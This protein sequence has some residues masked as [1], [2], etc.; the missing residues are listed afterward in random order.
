MHRPAHARARARA[1][2]VALVAAVV[3]LAPSN[4]RAQSEDQRNAPEVR[5]LDLNGVHGV[6]RADLARAISTSRST[7]RSPLLTPFCRL[8]RSPTFVDRKYLDRDEFRRD[9]LRILV[10]YWKRGFREAQVD[11]SVTRIA[12]GAVRVVFDIRE[13]RPTVITSL[14]IEHDTAVLSQRRVNRLSIL[15]EGD[16]LN[17]VV[18]DTMRMGFQFA[19]WDRGYADAEVDTVITVDPGKPSADVLLR[20]R[21]NWRTTVGSI[22]VR[23]NQEV[24]ARTIQNTI[25]L[26]PG[27]VFR[28]VDLLESQ[29]NLY[30]SNL[31]R[32]ASFSIPPRP[33]SVK[34]INIEVRETKM[35]EAR[36][37]AGVNNIDYIQVDGGYTNYNLF[38]G[39]RQFDITGIIGNLGAQALEGRGF[40][41]EPATDFF[42]SS[43]F[44]VPT[45]QVSVDLTQPAWLGQ[46]ENALSIGGFAHRRATPAVYID[47]GYGS[48]LVF[49]RTL[50]P[51]ATASAGYRFEITRVE[52]GDVYFCINFGVC[53]NATVESLRLH[54]SLS[55]IQLSAAIDRSDIPFNP[56]KGYI[57]RIDLEHAS[58][59]TLSDYRFNRGFAEASAY[60]HFR[61]ASRDPRSQVLAGR[62]RLG[63]VRPLAG[64]RTGIELLHPATRF[65]AGGSQSVRGYEENQLGPRILTI[66][67]SDLAL[68]GCDTTT[69]VTIELC[70]PN[71]PVLENRA[72]TPRPVGGTSLV[73]GNVEYRVPFG[74]R[75]EWAVF[76]DGAILG[77]S[78]LRS[79]SDITQLVNGTGAITPGVGFRYRSPVGPIRI[80]VG[81]NPKVREALDVVTTVSDSIGQ[82][83]LVTLVQRREWVGGG[84]ARGFWS[85]FNRMVLHLSIGQAF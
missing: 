32:L 46:P 77:G 13:G 83:V 30:E 85:L 67:P 3:A 69:A 19:M 22:T 10:F 23:G 11:T 56:T 54:Q 26:R 81:Y 62:L 61:Y 66:P 2:A 82:E 80:D 68:A 60:T 36:V 18:L 79:L 9:V 70:D 28:Y 42:D 64:N 24:S 44:M 21:A 40:F 45:W 43:A 15:R 20:V 7:C 75:M 74:T 51:R 65:Y 53:D 50:A 34:N 59:A 4:L 78:E 38:G 8:S 16:P 31:F 84:T 71:N 58:R 33:D 47:K 12:D 17:L 41:R 48:Q 76:L 63:Y 25:L 73:E 29:R 37:A 55:P 5:D 14:R 52:A 49:T 39:G 1:V 35:H 72:F 57:A 27:M 6:S